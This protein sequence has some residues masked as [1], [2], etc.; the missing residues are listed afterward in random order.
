M[1]FGKGPAIG[2]AFFFRLRRETVKFRNL[3]FSLV[4]RIFTF[5]SIQRHNQAQ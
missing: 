5:L 4:V 3:R 2:G 1:T